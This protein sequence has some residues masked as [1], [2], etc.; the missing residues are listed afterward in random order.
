MDATNYATGKARIEAKRELIEEF[1]RGDVEDKCG[2]TLLVDS[3][4]SVKMQ[5][6]QRR[7][8]RW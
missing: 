7:G 5:K 1:W 6:G 8:C 3:I 4:N 2:E